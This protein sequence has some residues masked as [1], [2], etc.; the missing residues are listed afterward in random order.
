MSQKSVEVLDTTLRDGA[1]TVNVSFTLN[2]KL[3]LAQ[4]LDELGV[5]YIEG[6]WPGSNPK[7]EE[8]FNQVKKLSLVHS[9]V[10]AFGSTKKS[11]S[12]ADE[13]PSLKAI[14][15]S[16]AE[17]A[18]VFGKT[19]ILHVDHVLK[20]SRQENLDLIHD[21][22]SY[23][24]SLGLKVIFDAEHFYQGFGADREYALEALKVAEEA[25]VD[26]ITLADTN[27]GTL[28][29][30]VY[31]VTKMVKE[32]IKSKL[33]IHAHNDLGCGVAN[34]LMGVMA[35]ARHIQGTINGLG[36]RT[37]NADLVQVIPT[38]VAKLGLGALKGRE[39]LKM[40]RNVSRLVSELAGIP[41]NPYQPYIGDNAF[42]HKA[43]VHVDAVLKNT[44]AYEHID[45]Q[46]VGNTRSVAISELSG[47]ANL[48]THATNI[49]GIEVKKSDERLKRALAEVKRL[50]KAGYSFDSSPASALLILMRSLGI[51]R[52]LIDM[53]Y[54]K[55]I[56]ETGT[57]IG[58]VKA[59]SR[60]RVAEGKGP[61]N[62]VDLA[63]R[64]ALL[65]DYPELSK[66]TLVDYKV[67]L[68]GEVKNTESMVR[69]TVEFA[70]ESNSWRTMGVSANVIEASVKAL[71]DGLDFFL[72]TRRIA[73]G[74]TVHQSATSL[75]P[76][77]L[78]GFPIR[79]KS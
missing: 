55:V 79:T 51:Y 30:R 62:A 3:R 71:V 22:L 23:L 32:R 73:K 60:L 15:R 16:G 19:W 57:S 5:D 12:R 61:I 11:G 48:V 37:G 53:Q 26:V 78:T 58:L 45:P 4:V 14:A 8:F 70:D 2:D 76:K 13:D 31:E 49:L 44:S 6:G 63:I 75:H 18:V 40:L 35:G 74:A 28:P 9:K 50:E 46:V 38:L 24:K 64:A 41:P 33:G 29:S 17:V 20:V 42:T 1:Q 52:K 39:S 34:T 68:P 65:S 72:Q 25:K 77:T 27:G 67:V 7:D 10:A 69:V 59:N 54:W 21:S 66:I 43:G 36:E 47:T 56:S